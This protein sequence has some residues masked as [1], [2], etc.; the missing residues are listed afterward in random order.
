MVTGTGIEAI[1]VRRAVVADADKVRYRVYRTPEDFIAVI[2][3]SALMAM[4]VS[5]VEDPFRIVRD[6]PNEHVA[7]DAGKLAKQEADIAP[8]KV[9]FALAPKAKQQEPVDMNAVKAA[10]G[11]D[12]VP[13]QLRDLERSK[14]RAGMVLP[15]SALNTDPPPKPAPKEPPIPVYIAPPEEPAPAPVEAAP[16]PEPPPLPDSDRAL[17]P[18]EVEQL[19]KNE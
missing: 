18:E 17:T 7:M 3:E 13:M 4:R 15:P 9:N 10:G 11:F 14:M 16:A 6:L 2:A 1:A 19:L 5:G 12:F 8:Q